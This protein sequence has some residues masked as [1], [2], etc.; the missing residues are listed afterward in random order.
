MSPVASRAVLF[1]DLYEVVDPT[2]S[3]A[4][5]PPL[6]PVHVHG[7]TDTSSHLC[8]PAGK[9]RHVCDLGLGEPHGFADHETEVMVYGPRDALEVQVVLGLVRESLDHARRANRADRRPDRLPSLTP[10]HSPPEGLTT[11]LDADDAGEVLTLQRAA[12]VTEAR[13]HA[14]LELPPLRQS[15]A[16]VVDELGDPRVRALGWRDGNGR[17]VAAVRARIDAPVAEIGR[18]TVAP[19][20]QGEGL[21]SRVLA[22]VERALPPGV[23]E[24]RLFTGEHSTGNLRLYARL[25]YRETHRRPTAAGYRLVHLS[26]RRAL[27]T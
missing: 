5:G 24:L 23:S 9:A 18:L 20:R 10:D 3:L 8:L 22:A 19:D 21:G 15:L 17:L 6:E 16:E 11:A 25:G 2:T 13:I 7:V 4:P 1:D 12:Y 14:D 26:K 27:D